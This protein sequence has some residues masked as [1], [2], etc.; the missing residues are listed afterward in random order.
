MR[1][2]LP[3]LLLVACSPSLS[4]ECR[5]ATEPTEDKLAPEL[6]RSLAAG[7]VPET[8][9]VTLAEQ[10]QFEDLPDCPGGGTICPER[11]QALASYERKVRASQRCAQ[12]H[13]R[14]LG[15]TVLEVFLYS[16]AFGA[17]LPDPAAVTEIAAR[18]DVARASSEYP[19]GAH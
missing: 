13:V 9:Y 11:E 3:L 4:S 7:T 12:E 8:V 14:S 10:F 6:A 17:R 15:G 19:I 2:V 18:A 1:L 16:N 5:V